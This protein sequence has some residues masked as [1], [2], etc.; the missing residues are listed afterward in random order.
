MAVIDSLVLKHQLPGGM[1]T[2]LVAQLKEANVLH[3]LIYD[4]LRY[5]LWLPVR[6]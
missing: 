6:L 1:F 3:W 4:E 2:N 5:H